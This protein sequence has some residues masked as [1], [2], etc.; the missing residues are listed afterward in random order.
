M[1]NVFA[2][3]R[4]PI[5][6][7]AP[8]TIDENKSLHISTESATSPLPSPPHLS[9]PSNGNDESLIESHHDKADQSGVYG[10]SS[11]VAADGLTIRSV[12][13]WD[14]KVGPVKKH[15]VGGV[16]VPGLRN[17]VAFLNQKTRRVSIEVR[18]PPPAPSTAAAAAGKSNV[19]Q[20]VK[21][22]IS[23]ID[24]DNDEIHLGNEDAV[25]LKLFKKRRK[26]R[27]YLSGTM[28]EDL[29]D[30][31]SFAGQSVSSGRCSARSI[32]SRFIF[33][34]ATSG[35]LAILFPQTILAALDLFGCSSFACRLIIE[36]VFL[37][38]FG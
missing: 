8:A 11:M 1:S 16:M 20:A 29:D 22:S 6:P 27:H 38:G 32:G 18:S 3:K 36:L 7:N 4:H 9:P 17:A 35:K 15:L 2:R 25:I 12:C 34:K 14:I 28:S 37:V 24:N 5:S 10:Q 13:S 23:S 31:A 26:G 21:E 33:G 19:E 30:D